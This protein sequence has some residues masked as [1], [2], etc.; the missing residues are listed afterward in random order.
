MSAKDSRFLKPNLTVDFEMLKAAETD[1][2]IARLFRSAWGLDR[3]QTGEVVC[4]E[5]ECRERLDQGLLPPVLTPAQ[6]ARISRGLA[7]RDADDDSDPIASIEA[8]RSGA[9]SGTSPHAGHPLY[10]E[11]AALPAP[12]KAS[13]R[14]DFT[15]FLF[16]K[17]RGA[18]DSLTASVYERLA[19]EAEQDAKATR[20]RERERAV[21]EAMETPRGQAMRE[22]LEKRH[23]HRGTK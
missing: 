1:V 3:S 12:I 15:C 20:E 18:L 19:Q 7:Y 13:L 6:F 16:V 14:N 8:A 10:R 23:S 4:G 17:Q 22:L 21:A 2:S 9:S 5:E 11:Y